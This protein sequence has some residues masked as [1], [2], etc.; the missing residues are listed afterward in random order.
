MSIF[1]KLFGRS[2]SA[3]NG[4]VPSNEGKQ[5]PEI[6]KED[7]VDDTEPS[8]ELINSSFGTE[9]PIDAIYAYL[10]R[11]Y[12]QQGYEDSMCNA[13][14]SYK[15][16]KKEI[17][18][19]GLKRLFSQVRLRYKDDLRR[20]DVQINIVEQQ[21]MINTSS[22]L[23]AKKETFLEHMKTIDEMEA[24]LINDEPQMLGMID[25]YNR[26]FLKGLAAIS[27]SYLKNQQTY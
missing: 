20:I 11:D 14:N 21:G 23:K 8:K 1:S 16:S 19:N 27:Q 18:K 4:D 2:T 3:S 15:D 24:S 17:I 22:S 10:E 6:K 7:F 5:L 12:E 9:M 13:D 25:S 26:G